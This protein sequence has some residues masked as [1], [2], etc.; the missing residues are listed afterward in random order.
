MRLILV[1]VY[2]VETRISLRWLINKLK[3]REVMDSKKYFEELNKK[4]DEMP[5]EELLK[6]LEESGL[7]KCPF[8]DEG[9][10]K[11]FKGYKPKGYF[12]VK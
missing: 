7:E 12:K 9:K 4:L 8:E 1:R 2:S 6:I 10:I 5:D 3:R 11:F